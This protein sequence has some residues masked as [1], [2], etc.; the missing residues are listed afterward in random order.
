[1]RVRKGSSMSP[2]CMQ[3][4]T[5]I[6]PVN[7]R[8]VATISLGGGAGN[9]QYDEDADRIYVTVH[10]ANQLAEI[11]PKQMRSAARL[12]LLNKL[13]RPMNGDIDPVRVF[14]ILCIARAT[15]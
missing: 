12:S 15:S 14:I 11:D 3:T 5:V 8:V 10:G 7:N 6:D 4:D 1:M 2:I 13:V 9:T